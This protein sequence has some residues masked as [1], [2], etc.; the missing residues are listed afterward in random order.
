MCGIFAA[1]NHGAVTDGL[2]NGL[3]ALAYRGYDSAGIAVI[4]SRG[5]ERRRAGGKLKHLARLIAQHPIDGAV[6]IAH[7]RWATHGEPSSTNAH[8][9]MTDQ[10]AVAHNGI[11]ENYQELRADLEGDGYSFESDTDSE[12]IPLLITRFLDQGLGNVH[13]LRLTMEKLKGSFALVAL[14]NNHPDTLYAARRASPL[15]IGRAKDG[16]YLAS[17]ANAL[18]N[19]AQKICHLQDGDLAC[20]QRHSLC[21]STAEQQLVERPMQDLSPLTQAPQDKQGYRHFMLKEIH[22]QPDVIARILGRYLVSRS[23]GLAL[24]KLPQDVSNIQRLSLIACGTSLFAGKVARYWL[25]SIAAIP[26]QTDVA[27]EFRYRDAPIESDSQAV[28]ISQSGETADTLAA[29]RYVKQKG[30]SCFSLVNQGQSS[31]ANESEAVMQ[32]LAGI[33]VGVASTKAFTAQL[34][35][36]LLFTIHLAKANRQLNVEQVQRLLNAVLTLP[37]QMAALL[38]P[39]AMREIETAAKQ[40]QHAN[41][42]LYLGRGIAYPLAQEGAL[43]LKEISY[44]HAEAYPAGELKHGPIALI[45]DQM[46][47]VMIAPPG[48]MNDK[49]LSNLREVHARGAKITLISN[50]AGITAARE[51]IQHG[52]VMPD[53][54]AVLQPLIYSLPLQ[55][56]AYRIAALKGTDIDQPR[57][58][59][60]AVTVE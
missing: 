51:Y 59:A 54:E 3:Q 37:E 12:V 31:M 35:V 6:G 9:H 34:C 42:I 20:V 47:V 28:F 25:E 53:T 11:I 40:L 56:L 16:F 4:N 1:I 5:L 48:R 19:C 22:Q 7:T 15:V 33:E 8:P 60:K 58:L 18:A 50:Q 39:N 24:T 43:K 14:F 36:L 23:E 44:I 10:V 17:D 21:I 46:P 2:L 32:S 52:I 55:L 57:N 45:D 30:Q 27:S 26:T 38:K 49:S 29:L 13:A 41:S